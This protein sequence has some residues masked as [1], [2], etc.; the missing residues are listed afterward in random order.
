MQ[1]NSLKDM[2]VST[3]LASAIS[4]SLTTLNLDIFTPKKLKIECEK[5]VI[6][7]DLDF[8]QF[9]LSRSYRTSDQILN[10]FFTD[11]TDW[12]K[13]YHEIGKCEGE[14]NCEILYEKNWIKE[15]CWDVGNFGIGLN[16]FLRVFCRGK[17]LKI[18]FNFFGR[19]QN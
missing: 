3:S 9:G 6:S 16:G 11:C 2:I 14:K 18:F 7:T 10:N 4:M 15:K 5:G 8:T 19:C 12:N 13:F 17:L 1:I